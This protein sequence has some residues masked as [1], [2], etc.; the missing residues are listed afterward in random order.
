M[1]ATLVR[2]GKADLDDEQQLPLDTDN[3]GIADSWELDPANGGTL[4]KGG[5]NQD[6]N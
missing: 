2:P 4:A 1:K 5:R 6:G 3:D